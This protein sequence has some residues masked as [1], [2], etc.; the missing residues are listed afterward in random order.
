MSNTLT[1]HQAT[2]V[3]QEVLGQLRKNLVLV[4]RVRRD[5]D[6]E[7]ASYGKVVQVPTIGSLAAND[8]TAGSD[9]T[10]QDATSS[11]V[12]VTLN[13][14]K[15][16]T[17]I[18][19]DIDKALSRNDVM[20]AYTQSAVIALAEKVEDDLFGL[21]ATFSQTVGTY[22]TDATPAQT[23]LAA[24]LLTDGKAPREGRTLV[25]ATK[26]VSALL[27]A[28]S[29][30]LAAAN[31]GGDKARLEERIIGR[32]MGF[33]V[34]ESQAVPLHDSNQTSSLAFHRDA[35][36]LVVRPLESNIPAGMG[37]VASVVNDPDS[38]LSIRCI[39]S[40]N[41]NRLGVQATVDILYGFA[42]MRDAFG[43]HY[44]T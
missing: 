23:R 19:E 12:S 1:A 25:L 27:T 5:F 10:V 24:K 42:E 14:H 31:T 34:M 44:K 40:Y 39:L 26:D 11:S 17:F 16:A 3:A 32:Y 37:A 28:D 18:I 43:I 13:K 6:T 36:A 33:D 21:Y 8:K 2:I 7:V 22:A 30:F 9:V 29:Q 20:A 4:K 38:G 41:A 35:I 15:E